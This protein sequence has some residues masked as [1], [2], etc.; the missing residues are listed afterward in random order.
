[1]ID[2]RILEKIK[3]CLRLAKSDNPHEAAAAMRQ[4]RALMDKHNVHLSAESLELEQKETETKY[5][6]APWWFKAIASIVAMAF[7]CTVLRSEKSLTFIGADGYPDL[8]LYCLDIVV[9]QAGSAKESFMR[10]DEYL[11]IRDSRKRKAANDYMVGWVHGVANGVREFAQPLTEDEHSKH[12]EYH[13]KLSNGSVKVSTSKSRGPQVRNSEAL[14]AGYRDGQKI[15]INQGINESDRLQI[16]FIK[17][18]LDQPE[19]LS[20]WEYDF[21]NDL[22]DKDDDYELTEKQNKVLNRISQRLD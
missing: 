7:G 8:A 6:R 15:K 9:R 17:D 4:A 19:K 11:F 3:K 18:A 5:K 1:M 14:N 10:S 16:R 13:Q 21:I 12:I 22:A 2:Q 20:D